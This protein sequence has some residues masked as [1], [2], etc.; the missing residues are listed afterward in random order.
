MTTHSLISIQLDNK[1][2]V[3]YCH[4]DGNLDGV[5]KILSVFYNTVERA[6][7]LIALGD[8]RILNRRLNDCIAYHRDRRDSWEDHK[9]IVCDNF[10]E[11]LNM[12]RNHEY[13]YYFDGKQWLF[14]QRRKAQVWL[15]VEKELSISHNIVDIA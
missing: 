4:Y 10:R 13:T 2:H 6:K 15:E 5:G 7:R 8:I 11:L 1:I 3:I 9:P 12:Q 14:L